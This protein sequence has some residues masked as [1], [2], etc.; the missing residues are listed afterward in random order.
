MF[1]GSLSY[2]DSAQM[3][4]DQNPQAINPSVT[5][6][7]LHLGVASQSGKLSITA[8]VNNLLNQHYATDVEDFWSSP[9]GGHDVVVAQPAR[10][11]YRYGGIRISAGF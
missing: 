2:R 11:N 8:F 3:L 7:G 6:I 10:D 4:A 5:L 9:W 1:G